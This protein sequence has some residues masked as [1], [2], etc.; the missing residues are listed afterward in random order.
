M[1][2]DAV[3]FTPLT[4]GVGE[5]GG[6]VPV[7]GQPVTYSCYVE[8]RGDMTNEEAM[9]A[10]SAGVPIGSTI[11][12]VYFRVGA[13]GLPPLTVNQRDEFTWTVHDGVNLP[14]PSTLVAFTPGKL[15]GTLMM[16]KAWEK[17]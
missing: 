14:V 13:N 10:N 15:Q 4:Y 7:P 16:V 1:F 6:V 2:N 17:V 3:N 11:H 12:Y 5:R 8:F 9:G